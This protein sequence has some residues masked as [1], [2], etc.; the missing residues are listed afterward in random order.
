M[1]KL[2]R[3]VDNQ[4]QYYTVAAKP[5][6]TEFCR[7]MAMIAKEQSSLM[8][9]VFP[10]VRHKTYENGILG[11][12]EKYTY[13]VALDEYRFYMNGIS[14]G[15][16][17]DNDYF[18]YISMRLFNVSSVVVS[19]DGAYVVCDSEELYQLMRNAE[20]NGAFDAI[21]SDFNTCIA[22]VWVAGDNGMPEIE[23]YCDWEGF[24]SQEIPSNQF[25]RLFHTSKGIRTNWQGLKYTTGI[26]TMVRNGK[27]GIVPNIGMAMIAESSN[28]KF[29][30]NCI[31]MFFSYDGGSEYV[32]RLYF[33]LSGLNLTSLQKYDT[34][35]MQTWCATDGDYYTLLSDNYT[36]TYPAYYDGEDFNPLA[37]SNYRTPEKLYI[38]R[39]V[40]KIWESI[41]FD[42]GLTGIVLARTLLRDFQTTGN[43][44]EKKVIG[45]G[46]DKAVAVTVSG[47]DVTIVDYSV[48]TY[49][50]AAIDDNVFGVGDVFIDDDGDIAIIYCIDVDNSEISAKK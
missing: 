2:K 11:V 19:G 35:A 13:D 32:V 42:S 22:S 47:S 44:L 38:F 16:S 6:G 50:K 46:A 7:V 18:L 39:M 27:Y 14:Q 15:Y 30:P 3:V 1:I 29:S 40:N 20:N 37:A 5:E 26:K 33:E 4:G 34:N 10:T 28:S 45:D 41:Y 24:T 23:Y 31:E 21:D 48:N 9:D 49:L 36:S 12:V 17:G 43:S 8:Y 25:Y